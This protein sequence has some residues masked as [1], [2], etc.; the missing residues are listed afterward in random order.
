[1]ATGRNGVV[2]MQNSGEGNA[3]NPLLSI[4]DPDV[5]SIPLLLVIG[6]RGEPGVHDE[7]QH[8]KQGKVTC[9][10][11]EAMGVPY[12]ILEPTRW[13]E[14]LDSLLGIMQDQ[15]RPVA[16]VV[17]KGTFS[18]YPFEAKVSGD[19]LLREQALEIMLGTLGP[20]DLVVSTTGKESREVFE[21]RERRGETHDAD[22]LTVGGMGH[23]ASIAYGMALG[24]P[25]STVWCLDG[26]GSMLMH[27]GSLAVM[28]Q[29][30]PSNL[31]YVVNVNGAH[32]SVGGQPNVGADID[33]PAM[34]RACGFLDV[35][36]AWNAAEITAS[37]DDVRHS[38][39]TALV[40]HTRQGSRDDLGRPTLSP[41]QNKL[42]LMRRIGLH[43]IAH[44]LT[45]HVLEEIDTEEDLARVS[46]MIRLRDFADQPVYELANGNLTLAGGATGWREDAVD[47]FSSL[48]A[49]LGIQ[50]PLV[51]ADPFFAQRLADVLD[52]A[53][54]GFPLFDG[55][56]PNPDIDQVAKA[57]EAY[58]AHGCDSVVSL[59]GGSAIDVAKCVAAAS[60]AD[61]SWQASLLGD[62][63]AKLNPAPHIAIP[64]TAGTG[65][66][67]TH[68]AVVYVDGKKVS[69]AANRLLPQVAVLCPSLLLGLP[70][71]QRASTLLDALCHAIE[72]HWSARSCE[73][74]RLH[75]A[76]A[77]RSIMT[78]W[79]LYMNGDEAAASHMMV[80][81]N[82]A[83]KAINITTTTAAH[84][85]CYG[86]TSRFKVAHG[87][88]A[89]LCLPSCWRKLLE[90]GTEETQERLQ[91]LDA[92]L[93]G[94]EGAEKGAGLACFEQL[95]HKLE[96]PAVG[97]ASQADLSALT[98]GVNAQRLANFPLALSQDEIR[99]MYANALDCA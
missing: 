26:D 92:L 12:E 14:Q 71:Y 82:H 8:V 77:I 43:A 52:G 62:G 5:Y 54:Q 81:A 17:R 2:Y 98:Q 1:M 29:T 49:L 23:T 48:F 35:R 93:C 59:G 31:R 68:F 67:S 4:A 21:I 69:V 57:V 7:P 13:T 6:W 30:W 84:A 78:N 75:S 47:D 85:M 51:V 88:A 50:R 10:M 70:H 25:E 94:D 64:S 37:M 89:A 95:V 74:S 44:S 63:L 79:R 72:S 34:L 97:P 3:V 76:R 42:A 28:A 46:H 11:L 38:S 18:A 86:I 16:L 20:H 24:C 22:F 55:V 58:R 27:M 99:A 61:E 40:L 39:R 87:H 33:V 32:E 9:T 66:E 36:E 19:P 53:L 73:E 15:S 45:G 90:R 65:S 60:D 80:A 83:G 91:E 41:V 56:K 96:V